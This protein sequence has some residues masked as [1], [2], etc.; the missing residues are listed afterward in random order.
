MKKSLPLLASL[1]LVSLAASAQAIYKWTDEKGQLHYSEV[2][3]AN[4]KASKADI[5][6]DKS[7]SQIE[8]AKFL[9]DKAKEDQEAARRHAMCLAGFREITMLQAQRPVYTTNDK[10]EHSIKVD[11]A[12]QANA[13]AA[14]KQ[15]RKNCDS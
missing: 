8:R 4:V 1:M 13:I 2:P 7:A 12:N 5:K 11:P 6:V 14:Q 15:M 9:A 3:P 10:G